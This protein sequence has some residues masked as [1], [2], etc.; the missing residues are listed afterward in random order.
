MVFAP[1]WY[2]LHALFEK[3]FGNFTV[4]VQALAKAP[5]L[6]HIL[7]VAFSLYLQGTFFLKT[8]YWGHESAKKSYTLQIRNLIEA[9]YESLG[10]RPVFLGETGVPMDM[11]CVLTRFS[12]SNSY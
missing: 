1:H 10:E 4:N 5:L 9:G 8:F 7:R 6:W 12:L 11:K 2:D 3:R